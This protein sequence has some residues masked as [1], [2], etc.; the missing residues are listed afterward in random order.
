MDASS[1]QTAI[2]PQLTRRLVGL[3]DSPGV[4]PGNLVAGIFERS[5]QLL[6]RL[7][8]L[9]QFEQRW[10]GLAPLQGDDTP[11]VYA[12]WVQA[13]ERAPLTTPPITS[14]DPAAEP[15]SSAQPSQDANAANPVKLQDAPVMPLV[16]QAQVVEASGSAA[17]RSPTT[18]TTSPPAMPL[19]VTPTARIP[20]TTSSTTTQQ[21]SAQPVSSPAN[22]SVASPMMDAAIPSVSPTQSG[23]STP[24]EPDV[25][26][27]LAKGD[28]AIPPQSE[29]TSS[30]PA[31]TITAANPVSPA[32]A[33]SALPLVSANAPLQSDAGRS[34]SDDGRS[35]T[36][37][38]IAPDPEQPSPL[39]LVVA[40]TSPTFLAQ[41]TQPI[42][43]NHPLPI[44]QRATN[45]PSQPASPQTAQPLTW[46]RNSTS[47]L[48]HSPTPDVALI[49]PQ[50]NANPAE[51]SSASP[52]IVA[53][54]VMPPANP[55]AT[56]TLSNTELNR[57]TQQV[58]RK[59]MRRLT[60]ERER[61]GQ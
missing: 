25:N 15:I 58:E 60:V 55:Q 53:A 52:P 48:P 28:R 37:S 41:E 38:T 13:T 21:I 40:A 9:H 34:N 11:L 14:Q 61:R 27:P 42:N 17:A 39:P 47:A 35:L 50:A 31:A 16:I 22:L 5:H 6:Q 49:H 51:R 2:N 36:S 10:A 57:L 54:T 1:W 29:T 43:P 24:V 3:M 30:S 32:P 46:A 59:L 12:H 45:A 33:N 19:V 8:L 4:I 7:S 26:L 23:S 44:V 56:S 18:E 20:Q